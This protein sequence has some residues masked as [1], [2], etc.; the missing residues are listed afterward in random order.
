MTEAD[1]LALT[2]QDSCWVYRPQKTT[3]PSGESVFQK[4]LDGRQVY[5]NIPC[6]LSSPSGGK[7]GK[8]EPTASIDTDFLL[9][10]RPEVEIE[11]GDTV[12]V[13]RLGREYLTEKPPHKTG[14]L[15]DSWKVGPIVKKG[16]TYYIEV[17]TNVE[18]AEPVEYGHR[19]RGGRGFVPG[20]HMME[21]SLEELNQAL[22][23]FLREWLSDF[24]STHDL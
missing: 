19:T 15:Q 6:A 17:Y 12:K 20:K 2:Y 3:L 16:D 21:L 1:I 23:G 10:V 18:Y 13:I 5:E 7:L 9:F 24:I 11:P 8:K 4:G 22:P 14:R